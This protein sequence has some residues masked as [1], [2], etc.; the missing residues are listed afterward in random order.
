MSSSRAR[1]VVLPLLVVMLGACGEAEPAATAGDTPPDRA[2]VTEAP[3]DG[4]DVETTASPAGARG[5]GEITVGER[6]WTFVPT[7][8]CMVSGDE[9][10]VIA[11]QAL[12]DPRVQFSVDVTPDGQRLDVTVD[13]ADMM[14]QGDE[15]TVTIDGRQVAGAATLSDGVTST[16][17]RFDLVCG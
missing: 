7:I 16:E 17:A 6:T 1:R 15:V 3:P 9:I 13:D 5:G 14:A 2:T 8:Q 4:P 12:D 10:A 11:G